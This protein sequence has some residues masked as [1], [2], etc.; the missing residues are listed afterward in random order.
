MIFEN[1]GHY[2][3]VQFNIILNWSFQNEDQQRNLNA[4]KQRDIFRYMILF[5]LNFPNF[6]FKVLVKLTNYL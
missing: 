4:D 6:Y 5:F 3:N 2:E 1:Y